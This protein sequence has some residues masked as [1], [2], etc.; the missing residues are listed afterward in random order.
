[1]KI[2]VFGASGR[3]GQH[4]VRLAL[5]KQIEVT[6]FVRTPSKL[7]ISH[8][9]LHI[10][11]GNALQAND[12]AAAIKGQTAVVSCLA[13][14]KGLKESQELGKMI[15]H[16]VSGM[17]MHNVNRII[18]TAS[19]GIY[20][21]IPGISGKM[22]MKTLKYPLLDHRHAVDTIMKY[23]LDYTIVRPMGLTNGEETGKYREA[24]EGIPEKGRSIA[25]AD[26][27]NFILKALEDPKYSKQSIS[28]AN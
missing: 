20:G 10:Y 9:F 23:H 13:S 8:P 26:V 24:V 18:Y 1:M 15:D 7:Q 17:E 2:V 19:A 11:H 4:V 16:I 28:I 27:A 25:R 14:S 12:V 21:E 22:I 3:V 5:E 6:A